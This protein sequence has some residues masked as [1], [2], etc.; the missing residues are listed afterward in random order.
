MLICKKRKLSAEERH[1]SKVLQLES[2][3]TGRENPFISISGFEN[4]DSENMDLIE[5]LFVISV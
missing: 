4:N 3:R 1:L 5:D 2:S